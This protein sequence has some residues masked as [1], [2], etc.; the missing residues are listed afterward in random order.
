[1]T[2]SNA[3][4]AALENCYQEG[5]LPPDDERVF[6]EFKSVFGD[7]VDFNDW[8]EDTAPSGAVEKLE[9]IYKRNGISVPDED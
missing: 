3:K 1:M 2:F 8:S 7:D 5:A 6:K 9:E 4:F